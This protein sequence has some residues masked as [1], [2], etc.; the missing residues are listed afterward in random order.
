MAFPREENILTQRAKGVN[1]VQER[2][3]GQR[4]SERQRE[5][6]AM[7]KEALARPGVKEMMKVYHNWVNV[8]RVYESCLQATTPRGRVTTTDHSKAV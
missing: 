3:D 8:S 6:D 2:N 1:P 4:E 5:L 7:L